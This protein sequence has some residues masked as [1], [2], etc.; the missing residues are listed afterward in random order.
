MRL[1]FPVLALCAALAPCNQPAENKT[2]PPADTASAVEAVKAAEADLLAAFAAKDAA[3]ITAH[4]APDAR[5]VVPGAPPRTPADAAKD[6]ED[7]AFGIDFANTRTQVSAS[8][9]LAYTRGTFTVAFTDPA[10]G[11]PGKVSGNYVTVFAKAADGSWKIVEDIA[12]AGAAPA[13]S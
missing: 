5:I 4:Y 7:P 1:R 8:G 11:K 6:L 3:R 12:S 9:D 2:A 10:T 13:G